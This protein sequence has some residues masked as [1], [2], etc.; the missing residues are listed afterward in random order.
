MTRILKCMGTWS[1]SSSCQ[2]RRGAWAAAEMTAG[3][4][5]YDMNT[6]FVPLVGCMGGGS[7]ASIVRNKRFGSEHDRLWESGSCESL[8]QR[9]AAC[10]YTMRDGLMQQL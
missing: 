10:G 2:V 8:L 5:V 7:N 6:G 1:A 9:M 4:P 3:V